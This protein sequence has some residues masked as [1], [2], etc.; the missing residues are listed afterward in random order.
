MVSTAGAS[1]RA[2]E[3]QAGRGALYGT[4]ARLSGG[5]PSGAG[6]VWDLWLWFRES[7]WDAIVAWDAVGLGAA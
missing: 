1:R 4:H 3:A 6:P 5:L 2:A 7:P